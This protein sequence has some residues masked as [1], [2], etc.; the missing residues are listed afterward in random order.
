M[1]LKMLTGTRADE[2][3]SYDNIIICISV[4]TVL[5]VFTSTME[6][7]TYFLYSKKVEID[8]SFKDPLCNYVQLFFSSIQEKRSLESNKIQSETLM[9]A[10][11]TNEKDE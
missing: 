3:E 9:H 7:L 6:A 1:F 2:D 11:Y 4:S 8:N 10:Q 5:M